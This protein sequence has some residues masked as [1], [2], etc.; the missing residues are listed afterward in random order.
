MPS[1]SYLTPRALQRAARGVLCGEVKFL[2]GDCA[3][4]G[5]FAKFN[6]TSRIIFAP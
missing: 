5:E 1:P 2:V 6:A 4:N 3:G